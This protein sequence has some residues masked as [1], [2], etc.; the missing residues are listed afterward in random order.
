MTRTKAREVIMQLIF[1]MEAQKDFSETV[2]ETFL[3]NNEIVED[4][5]TRNLYKAF[6][7]NF[8]QVDDILNQTAENWTT[9][10]INRVDLAILR[11]TVAELMF[12][13]V[14]PAAVV[15]NEAVNL[16]KKYGTDD[17]GKFVN[18]VLG[19]IYKKHLKNEGSGQKKAG[20]HD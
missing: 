16:A 18:G 11:S 1:I 8:S 3:K 13:K 15:I 10:R 2:R 4:V 12:L 7:E 14:A 20:S 19:G 17:S 5:F 9:H 6:M